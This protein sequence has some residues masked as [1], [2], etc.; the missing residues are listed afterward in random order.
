VIDA[1]SAEVREMIL[2]G[3]KGVNDINCSMVYQPRM[4]GDHRDGVAFEDVDRME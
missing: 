2:S 1:W 3:Q 4:E